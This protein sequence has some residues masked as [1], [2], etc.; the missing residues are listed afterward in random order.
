MMGEKLEPLRLTDKKLRRDRCPVWPC[1]I[2]SRIVFRVTSDAVALV[3]ALE[4]RATEE[5]ATGKTDWRLASVRGDGRMIFAVIDTIGPIITM[6]K[7]RKRSTP[8][9]R[10]H[11]I[12]SRVRLNRYMRYMPEAGCS[13][14]HVP[15]LPDN[16][17]DRPT[18]R[19]AR[20]VSRAMAGRGLSARCWQ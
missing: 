2:V 7:R 20:W 11:Y 10:K 1:P 18:R 9:R 13:S 17:N 19:E 15:V 5:K 4:R 14:S 3:D 6:L 8:A 12:C 16:E